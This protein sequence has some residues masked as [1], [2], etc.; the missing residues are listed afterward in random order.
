MIALAMSIFINQQRIYHP[1]KWQY[2]PWLFSLINNL[3]S[4]QEQVTSLAMSV[5]ERCGIAENYILLLYYEFTIES[6]YEVTTLAM[7]VF[8]NQQ[9]MY[10]IFIA[11]L[12][13][14]IIANYAHKSGIL[15]NIL[16]LHRSGGRLLNWCPRASRHSPSKLL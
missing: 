16:I 12:Q 2:L 10:G 13:K 5:W 15:I 9:R 3:R 6:L 11:M 8:I 14:D 7:S 4:Q 1:K